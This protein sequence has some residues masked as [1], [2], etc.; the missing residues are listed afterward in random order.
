MPEDEFFVRRG[1]D[2]DPAERWKVTSKFSLV[3]GE[4][5]PIQ[6]VR[7]RPPHLGYSVYFTKAEFE[8]RFRP[9]KQPKLR[10]VK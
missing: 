8:K 3:T 9:A 7:L 1:R 2:V 10:L 5:F 4:G 6:C